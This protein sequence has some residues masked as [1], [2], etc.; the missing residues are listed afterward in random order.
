MRADNE[1]G[2]GALK[3]SLGRVTPPR[4]LNLDPV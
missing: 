1:R 4:P 2:G 3:G